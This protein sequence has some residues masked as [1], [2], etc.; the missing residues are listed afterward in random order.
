MIG[1]KPQS[2]QKSLKSLMFIETLP[3]FF[4][5][6][7]STLY[8]LHLLDIFYSCILKS[9]L[10][11][12]GYFSAVRRISSASSVIPVSFFIISLYSRFHICDMETLALLNI[13]HNKILVYYSLGFFKPA[14]INKRNRFEKPQSSH[15][16][17]LL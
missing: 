7:R 2:N 11:G 17:K 5:Q 3:F 13:V 15:V 6:I 9:R 4:Q 12:K 1:L 8:L 14:E 10:R 16:F